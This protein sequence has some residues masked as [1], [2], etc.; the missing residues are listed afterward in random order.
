[1]LKHTSV[2]MGIPAPLSCFRCLYLKCCCLTLIP[3]GPTPPSLGQQWW[4]VEVRLPW[5]LSGPSSAPSAAPQVAQHILAPHLQHVTFTPAC[6][7]AERLHEA[8]YTPTTHTPAS[9]D[10]T[11]FQLSP[12]HP[13]PSR[14]I[15]TCLTI[16]QPKST[17][18]CNWSLPVPT[19]KSQPTDHTSHGTLQY[20][21]SRPWSPRPL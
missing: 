11:S 15:I 3:T 21:P 14:H 17:M 18:R 13:Y 2:V 20:S 10:I 1:M 5:R 8:P 7:P 6:V 16:L 12:S 9:N 4:Q 19:S